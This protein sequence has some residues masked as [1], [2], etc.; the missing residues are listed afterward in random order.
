MSSA[1]NVTIKKSFFRTE[2]NGLR[3]LSL[4]FVVIHHINKNLIPNSYL[5]V[6]IFFVISGYVLASSNSFLIE[7][8]RFI[9]TLNFFA[10]R[11]QRLLP[12]LLIYLIIFSFLICFFDGQPS[13]S[14]K[15][16]LTSI[17]GL[18]N[19]FLYIS[20]SNYFSESTNLNP[21]TQTWS[22]SVE[23]QFYILELI[24]AN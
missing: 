17:F 18:S 21:F 2:L 3:A 11:F 24:K 1:D 5:G 16:G 10:K 7:R 23:I 6:D 13:N 19:I 22:L 4:F 8:N 12:P 9:Y 20:S 15:T 14:I